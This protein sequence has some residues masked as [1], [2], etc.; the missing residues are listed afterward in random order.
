MKVD[1]PTPGKLDNFKTQENLRDLNVKD[2]IFKKKIVEPKKATII[3]SKKQDFE[4]LD[5]TA[6]EAAF[7]LLDLATPQTL[8]K[9]IL[10]TGIEIVK[11][12][13]KDAFSGVRIEKL[14]QHES[15]FAYS[16]HYAS[17]NELIPE[18]ITIEYNAYLQTLKELKNNEIKLPK[19][20]IGETIAYDLETYIL[21][22]FREKSL[23]YSPEDD[24]VHRAFFAHCCKRALDSLRQGIFVGDE[25]YKN[26]RPEVADAIER[27]INEIILNKTLFKNE[28]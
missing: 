10:E 19:D 21:N 14:P 12:K 20:V 23:K 9:K 27:R 1:S 8:G 26:K 22:D 25:G 3:E 24:L 28:V 5:L 13:V 18:N 6:K 15:D 16:W 7:S 17:Q 4:P 11:D 2:I